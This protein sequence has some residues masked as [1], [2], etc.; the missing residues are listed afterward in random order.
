MHEWISV[1]RMLPLDKGKSI[2][3]VNGHGLIRI[4]A[5]W[6]KCDNNKWLWIDST[7]CFKFYNDITHWMPLPEPP[8]EDEK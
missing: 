8:K 3:T 2:L 4:L 1:K 6:K 7:G 5:Y